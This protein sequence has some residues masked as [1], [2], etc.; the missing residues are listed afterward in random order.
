MAKVVEDQ[1]QTLRSM[2]WRRNARPLHDADGEQAAKPRVVL[3]VVDPGVTDLA[4]TLAEACTTTMRQILIVDGARDTLVRTSV[5]RH[6][7]SLLVAAEEIDVRY[8]FVFW[9]IP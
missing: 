9:I 8:D 2:S 3:F 4:E 6:R 7:V 1:A 5:G